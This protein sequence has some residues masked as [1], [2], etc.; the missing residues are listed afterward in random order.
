[1]RLVAG[2]EGA[3]DD[4]GSIKGRLNRAAAPLEQ[5]DALL[6]GVPGVRALIGDPSLVVYLDEHL[7]ALEGMVDEL[8]QGL[9]TLTSGLPAELE[10]IN[11]ALV[12][13][14]DATWAVAA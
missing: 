12:R 8:E 2:A 3:F 4:A 6:R 13:V 7:T 5:L 1:M 14:R 9:D 10:A 11:A